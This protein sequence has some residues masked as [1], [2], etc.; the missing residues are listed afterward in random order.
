MHELG[1]VLGAIH[2]DDPDGDGTR[3]EVPS[4]TPG[5]MCKDSCAGFFVLEQYIE[6]KILVPGGGPIQVELPGTSIAN[7]MN[8]VDENEFRILNLDYDY[9]DDEGEARNLSSVATA[10]ENSD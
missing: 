4:G 2:P 10:A 9:R 6:G 7:S 5:V 1:H 8:F 3:F